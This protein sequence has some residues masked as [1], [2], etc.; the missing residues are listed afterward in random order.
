[1]KKLTDK[2]IRRAG[3]EDC[4]RAVDAGVTVYTLNPQRGWVPASVHYLRRAFA[5]H[6]RP[7]NSRMHWRTDLYALA[8]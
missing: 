6:K 4:E 5:W 7:E 8:K 2:N 3:I 1:M